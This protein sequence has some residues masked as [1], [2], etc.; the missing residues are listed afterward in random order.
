MTSEGTIFVNGRHAPARS[1]IAVLP[2]PKCST[3]SFPGIPKPTSPAAQ[4][5]RHRRVRLQ[6]LPD[7]EKQRCRRDAA[8]HQVVEYAGTASYVPPLHAAIP[9]CPQLEVP[10]NNSTHKKTRQS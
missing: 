8:L 2:E 4:R 10:T 6:N 7:P 1:V 9:W 3:S 5:P